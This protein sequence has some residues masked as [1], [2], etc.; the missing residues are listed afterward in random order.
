[1]CLFLF[2][3]VVSSNILQHIDWPA[4][5]YIDMQKGSLEHLSGLPASVVLEL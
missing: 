5:Q 1:M 2:L 3:N 4:T